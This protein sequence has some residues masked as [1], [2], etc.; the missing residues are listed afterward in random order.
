A[1]ISAI[2]C[3]VEAQTGSHETQAVWAKDPNAVALRRLDGRLFE[4]GT[5][6][7]SFAKAGSEDDSCSN[8]AIPTL[9]NDCGNRPGGGCNDREIDFSVEFDQARVAGA[10]LKALVGRIDS[11]HLST[12]ASGNHVRIHNRSYRT[13]SVACAE[14]RN[15]P[16]LKE[17]GQVVDGQT[18]IS[19]DSNR[20]SN[21][22]PL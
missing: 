3:G 11:I 10:R 1:R 13:R 8:P 21:E 19:P 16:R 5:L 17:R 4:S 22:A 9:L 12:K 14:D 18:L 15:T 2:E 20:R 6:T 7:T